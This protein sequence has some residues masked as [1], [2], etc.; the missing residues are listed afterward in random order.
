MDTEINTAAYYTTNPYSK[1]SML[2]M[3]IQRNIN[4]ASFF[5]NFESWGYWKSG[6]NA[7]T[8]T[9]KLSLWYLL[10]NDNKDMANPKVQLPTLQST[11]YMRRKVN[12]AKV[13]QLNW[14][15]SPHLCE[16]LNGKGV[17]CCQS[18]PENKKIR[19]ELHESN[20]YIQS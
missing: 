15:P 7:F 5:L 11:L 13:N 8:N 20:K 3:F 6:H 9:R 1:T 18:K 2:F 19:Y 10:V 4:S 16:I 17:H 12:E 14:H